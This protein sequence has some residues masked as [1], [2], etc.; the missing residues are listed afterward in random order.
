MDPQ[1][2]FEASPTLPLPPLLLPALLSLPAVVVLERGAAATLPRSYPAAT[3]E[4]PSEISAATERLCI[5]TACCAPE[6]NQRTVTDNGGTTATIAPLTVT[7]ADK[8][9][10]APG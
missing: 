2:E 5:K 4:T 6:W 10:S 8:C 9:T 3:G 7:S 1:A